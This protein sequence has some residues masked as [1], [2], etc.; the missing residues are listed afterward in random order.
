MLLQEASLF[1]GPELPLSRIP[2]LVR[3]LLDPKISDE[4][5]AHFLRD[6]TQRGETAAELHAFSSA[7]L[8]FAISPGFE[9]K[10]N[11]EPLF[12]CCG[13]GGGGLNLLNIS[14][15]IV[16]ILASLG[17]PVV[18][19]GNRGV[20]KKSGSADVL[21]ALGIKIDLTPAQTRASLESV[22]CVFLLAP[23]FHPTFKTIASVR[24][25]LAAQGMRTIFNLLGPLLNPARP[26]AQLLGV[27][28]PHHLEL[29]HHVLNLRET[30]HAVVLGRD[31]NGQPIGEV[32]I[33]G[34]ND[35][36]SNRAL[37][38]SS[39]PP[40]SGMESL[41]ITSARESADRLVK[42]LQ[43]EDHGPGRALLIANAAAA[44]IVQGRA[45]SFEAGHALADEALSSG[46]A[47]ATLK[48][49]QQFGA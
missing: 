7:L 28:P 44:L 25:S 1:Q 43:N 36:R 37:N 4:P 41:L 32:S 12:D 34:S 30:A 13:T 6:L 21:E 18:K 29:F 48:R 26:T 10:W 38:L 33:F 27:F 19:H 46:K 47:F 17:V 9:K 20:T 39:I 49:W 23:H 45:D 2:E 42:L 22:G 3:E 11:G 31:S 8:P 14:T 15:G 5:K 24:K 16:P 40:Q 35:W